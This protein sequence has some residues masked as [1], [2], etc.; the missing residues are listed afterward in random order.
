[1]TRPR[2]D[3]GVTIT[4]ITVRELILRAFRIQEFQLSGGPG[5]IGS[6]RFDIDAKGRPGT[7]PAQTA[8][9]LQGL[10]KQRFNLAVHH[11]PRETSIYALALARSDGKLGPKLLRSNCGS[12]ASQTA[13]AGASVFYNRLRA[14]G[15]PISWMITPLS[16]LTQRVVEDRTGLTG[17]F[18]IDV[19]WMPDQVPRG[20]PAPDPDAPSLFTALQEQLGL[21]LESVKAPVDTVVIDNIQAPTDD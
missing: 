13:C 6:D 7:N 9:M 16:Q 17:N 10:L 11:E 5:W 20:V 12:T 21:K 4:N 15:A 1:M 2:P 18:D 3:G 19:T 14:T 8:V